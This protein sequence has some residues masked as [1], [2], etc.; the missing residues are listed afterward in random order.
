MVV[1]LREGGVWTYGLQ[2]FWA[3]LLWMDG[4]RFVVDHC[5]CWW[6]CLVVLWELDCSRVLDVS[7]ADCFTLISCIRW[8]PVSVEASGLFDAVDLVS[9][10]PPVGG[11][12]GWL[13]WVAVVLL[14]LLLLAVLA[15]RLES[16]ERNPRLGGSEGQLVVGF[17]QNSRGLLT[18]MP[19]AAPSVPLYH[20]RRTR[21]M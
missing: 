5:C 14:V 9:R 20:R 16:L 2:W 18:W 11:L 3:G 8:E 19:H 21:A 17:K 6:W 12:V 10:S 15:T 4:I 7:W 1:G 13:G